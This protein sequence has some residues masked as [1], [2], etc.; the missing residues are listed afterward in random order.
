MRSS[1]RTLSP[2]FASPA[3]LALALCL[4]APPV[5]HHHGHDHVPTASLVGAPCAGAGTVPHLHAAV[6]HPAPACPACA[7]GPARDGVPISAGLVLPPGA[8]E[9][10]PP[11]SV[12][13]PHSAETPTPRSRAPPA[14][15]PV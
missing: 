7:A 1:L 8:T 6:T 2:A 14:A 11:A 10:L 12:A 5:L 3:T 15:L 13:A 9:A 4:L